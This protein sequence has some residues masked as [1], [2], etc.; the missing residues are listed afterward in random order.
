M[1][2]TQSLSCSAD[3]RYRYSGK[4]ATADSSFKHVVNIKQT[5]FHI[6]F[7]NEQLALYQIY[8]K[9]IADKA[10]NRL[11][12]EDILESLKSNRSPLL[13]TERTE[14]LQII[15]DFLEGK[16]K[17]I[18]ILKGGMSKKQQD[19]TVSMM[20]RKKFVFMITWTSQYQC[21]QECIKEDSVATNLLGMRL[22][23]RETLL[24][25]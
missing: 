19:S 9:L 25:N 20:G 7:E 22:L 1:A 16:V 6:P 23:I 10:R 3:L 21:L 13:L 8:Q 15:A 2:I 5:G 12:C 11:I 4:E 17:N 14:H 24:E 18:I